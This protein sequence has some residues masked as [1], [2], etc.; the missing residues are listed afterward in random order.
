MIYKYYLILQIIFACSLF[1]AGLVEAEERNATLNKKYNSLKISSNTLI[2]QAKKALTQ[3]RYTLAISKLN[4]LLTKSDPNN[5]AFALEFLGVAYERDFKM[6]FAKKYYRLFLI[7]YSD[8]SKAARV[9]Q[10]LTAL[11]GIESLSND[12]SKSLNKGNKQKKKSRN[13]TRG[14]LSTSY[15]KSDLVN[16]VGERRETLSLVGTDIDIRGN[17]QLNNNNIKVRLSA[18]HYQDLINNGKATSD[19]L[20]YLNVRWESKD[21]DYKVD[22]GRQRN[23]KKGL[24]NRFDGAVFSYNFNKDQTLNFYTGAPVSSSKILSLDPERRFVGVSFDWEKLFENID[25]SIFLLNQTIGSLTDRRALGSEVKYVNQRTSAFALF[26]YDIF[27]SELNAL[28]LSGSFSTEQKTRF[29]WSLNQR[30]SPYISTRN[31]LI[32]QPADSLEE[33]QNL[34]LTD[35]EILDLAIDRTLESRSASFQISQPIS[36][37]YEI[38]ANLNWLD[39]SGAPAS[40]GV[41]EIINRDGQTYFNIYLRGSKLYSSSDTNQ[42]G[43]RISKLATSDIWSAYISSQYRWKRHWNFTG[44][45]R[46]DNRSNDNGS[47]Q[48]SISPSFRFQYQ[49]N[50]HFVY[51]E[52]GAI[53]YTNQI[54]NFRDLSTDIYYL[55]LGYQF[56][57]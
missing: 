45:L 51:T 26:D 52:L 12:N 7:K 25:A 40:G 56:Y 28:L 50:D 49:N 17:Y 20:S 46:Y 42:L 31:A 16:D 35:D 18:G 38:S 1:N 10:R 24:F 32:G 39:L 22:V 2:E 54:V 37:N 53:L 3:E 30:K 36:K 48:Q 15:R 55:Y 9:K 11:L 44:K 23:R 8:H 4:Q 43:F 6:A 19:R 33:L 13:N 21:G 29:S 57:F 5:K 47:G 41:P 34:F 14:S 27:H